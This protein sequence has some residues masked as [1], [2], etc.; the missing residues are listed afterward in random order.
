MTAIGR[1]AR[2]GP[3]SL[4]FIDSTGLRLVLGWD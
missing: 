3:G 1:Q 4:T 2:T